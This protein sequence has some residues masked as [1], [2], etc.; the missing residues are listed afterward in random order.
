MVNQY[1]G[2]QVNMRRSNA[3]SNNVYVWQPGAEQK[4]VSHVSNELQAKY[5]DFGPI[6]HQKSLQSQDF[7]LR[8]LQK[9]IKMRACNLLYF[10]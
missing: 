6:N 4:M 10:Y 9:P 8:D 2:I 7:Y 5:L 1:H 3:S